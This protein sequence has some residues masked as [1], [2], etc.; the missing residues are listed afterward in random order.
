MDTCFPLLQLKHHRVKSTGE[1]NQPIT[2]EKESERKNGRPG[3]AN[4]WEWG[5]TAGTWGRA[6][7]EGDSRR[8]SCREEDETGTKKQNEAQLPMKDA[9]PPPSQPLPH[10]PF[11]PHAS[12]RA[13]PVVQGTS[14]F[15]QRTG[16]DK[17]SSNLAGGAHSANSQKQLIGKWGGTERFKQAT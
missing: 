1:R 5:T 16:K 10:L 3:K 11:K 4:E 12:L 13:W 8:S 17:F 7:E 9:H 6:R 14:L 15:E 2:R